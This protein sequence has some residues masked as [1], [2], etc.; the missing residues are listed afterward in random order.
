VH[1]L[2]LCHVHNVPIK[3][4][5]MKNTQHSFYECKA[6]NVKSPACRPQATSS[7]SQQGQM[8]FSSELV[9]SEASQKGVCPASELAQ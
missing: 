9:Q 5:H 8:R 1:V 7:M 3:R 6:E 2:L 4:F